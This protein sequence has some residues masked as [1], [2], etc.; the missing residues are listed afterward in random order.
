MGVI[1]LTDGLPQEP[2]FEDQGDLW[3]GQRSG[4]AKGE[5]WMSF[6]CLSTHLRSLID[7]NKGTSGEVRSQAKQKQSDGCLSLD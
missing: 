4:K 7:R 6:S 3:K 1:L 5:C 2:D